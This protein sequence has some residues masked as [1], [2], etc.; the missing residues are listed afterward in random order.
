MS[1]RPVLR[2]RA[3]LASA[4]GFIAIGLMMGLALSGSLKLSPTPTAQGGPS[5]TA[6]ALTPTG[7]LSSP[8]ADVVERSTPAVVLIETKRTVSRDGSG[9]EDPFDMFRQLFPNGRGTPQQPQQQPRTLPASGSGF[10]IESSGRV[11]TNAH[12]VRDAQDIT[13]TLS[14]KRQFKAKVVGQ[15]RATDIA[16]L[17]LQGARG[18]LPTLPLGNSDAIRV[19]DW[20]LAVGTPLGELQGTVTAGIISAKGR[21][22]LNIMGGGPEYQDF[23]QTDAAIN[24]GNS[25]GPLL[26]IRGEVVGINT[27]INTSGQGIG[28]A[29]PINL[30]HH[31][32]DQLA[33]HG[34][35]VRGY[36]GVLPGELTPDLADSFGLK[37]TDGVVISQIVPDSP[38]ARAGLREGDVVTAFDNQPIRDVTDFRLRVADEGVN[39]RVKVDA[40]RDG[41]PFTAWVTM[42]DRDVALASQQG[43]PQGGSAGGGST[44][45]APSL[46]LDVRS[47]TDRERADFKQSGVI[48]QDVTD[49]SAA[50]DNGISAGDLVL[51]VNGQPVTD[52]ISFLNAVRRAHAT[53]TRPVRLLVGSVD[54]SGR[55]QTRFV[56]LRFSG[57]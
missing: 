55:T 3:Y 34:K 56:A 24:F 40:I 50:D 39:K 46:G 35:V 37:S 28:F 11:L 26:N 10:I 9:E 17:Q 51:Q 22:S 21:S 5:V 45:T 53:P 44:Q 18:S 14:D 48:V 1:E 43:S 2:P 38:A 31:I 7:N 54:D 12:V 30:A 6:A 57:E 8:F 15:D 29:I 52:R 25:G 41:K 13:V 49:G 32:A 16:V 19:G 36:M 47:M 42:A 33:S 27:A 4:V 20:A 23:I